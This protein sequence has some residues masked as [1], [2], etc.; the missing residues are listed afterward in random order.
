MLIVVRRDAGKQ[1]GSGWLRGMGQAGGDLEK[2][3]L[4]IDRSSLCM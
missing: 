1:S 3:A 2:A 4:Y